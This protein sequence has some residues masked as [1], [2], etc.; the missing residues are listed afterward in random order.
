MLKGDNSPRFWREA[1][2]HSFLL[3]RGLL[4]A[5]SL[6]HKS[7]L[8]PF[9]QQTGLY[10]ILLP[11]ANEREQ[12]CGEGGLDSL[13]QTGRDGIMRQ[14]RAP[15]SAPDGP[16]KKGFCLSVRDYCGCGTSSIPLPSQ[17]GG[18]CL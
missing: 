8:S 18:S 16:M 12:P 14:K 9:H 1:Y 10:S 13:W 5:Q 15:G 4:S 3:Y 11:G 6:S 2:R 17:C 7:A